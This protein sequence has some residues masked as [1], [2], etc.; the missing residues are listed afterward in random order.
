MARLFPKLSREEQA[1]LCAARPILSQ[2]RRDRLAALMTGP[3]DWPAFIAQADRH[4]VAPMLYGHLRGL[5]S[6][7]VPPPVLEALAQLARAALAWNLRLRHELHRLLGLFEEA[8]IPVVPLKGPL[9]GDL[10]YEEPMLRPTADLDLLVRP[11][12]RTAAGELLQRAGLFRYPDHEQGAEYHVS[13]GTTAGEG[14]VVELH[15]GLAEDHV[16]GLDL[17]AIWASALWTDWEGRRV[18]TMA[19]PHLLVYL[20]LHAVKDGLASLRPLLDITLLLERVGG[21]LPWEPISRTVHEAGVRRPVFLA[22]IH[23]RDL[24]DA[25]VP[26]EFL[27]AIRPRPAPGWLLG[28]ALFRWR[29]AVLHAAP[30]LLTGPVM[31]LQRLLWEDSLAGQL[32][33][34]RRNLLPSPELRGRWMAQ[35]ADGPLLRW[36]P[37]WLWTVCRRLAAQV[38][39]RPSDDSPQTAPATPR[40]RPTLHDGKKMI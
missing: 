20:C 3:L 1:L 4:G 7:L 17:D 36:Y 30:A 11:E 18:R 33:H 2:P 40:Q 10:F 38:L 23:C 6:G 24:L 27:D 34:L 25:P 32:R 21:R 8:G 26:A 35:P 22:L 39:S 14:V 12:H 29:G 37:A 16:A 31:A 28:L 5:P 9:L 19:P 15:S 13:Y